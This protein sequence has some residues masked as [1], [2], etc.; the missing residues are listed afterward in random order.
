MTGGPNRAT[1]VKK[2]LI[3][4]I[5]VDW[6]MNGPALQVSLKFGRRHLRLHKIADIK[7]NGG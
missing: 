4:T 1:L 5:L 2:S 7:L 6:R 3:A